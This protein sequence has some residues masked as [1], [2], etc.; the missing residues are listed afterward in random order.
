MLTAC[1]Q[2]VLEARSLGAHQTDSSPKS[3]PVTF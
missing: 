2:L 1:L 3:L